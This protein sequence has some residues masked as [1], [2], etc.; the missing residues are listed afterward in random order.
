MLKVVPNARFSR[1]LMRESRKPEDSLAERG[2][3]ELS[4][5]SSNR[6]ETNCARETRLSAFSPGKHN[7][8]IIAGSRSLSLF[9]SDSF[10]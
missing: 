6:Q 1:S 8:I 3:F 2:G 4:L 10:R 7:I 9:G 5:P